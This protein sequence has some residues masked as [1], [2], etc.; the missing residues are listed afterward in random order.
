VEGPSPRAHGHRGTI[1]GVRRSRDASASTTG[2]GTA[3]QGRWSRRG[4]SN[5]ARQPPYA[6]AVRERKRPVGCCRAYPGAARNP[7]VRAG[8]RLRG[9][10]GHQSRVDPVMN[11]AVVVEGGNGRHTIGVGRRLQTLTHAEPSSTLRRREGPVTRCRTR[12]SRLAWGLHPQVLGGEGTMRVVGASSSHAPHGTSR[13]T[14]V[15]RSA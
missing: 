5:D 1:G 4:S 7:S 13:T 10:A 15:C 14:D 2:K 3:A 9:F 11:G 6:A 8:S 12:T